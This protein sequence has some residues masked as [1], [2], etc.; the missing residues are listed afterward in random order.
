M[1]GNLQI[2]PNPMAEPDAA[3]TNP[4][5]DPQVPLTEGFCMMLNWTVQVVQESRA[6]LTPDEIRMIDDF[7]M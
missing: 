5:L 1:V 3:K 7:F 2:F 4:I 6:E